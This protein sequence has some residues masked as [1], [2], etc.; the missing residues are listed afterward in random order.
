[1]N[2]VDAESVISEIRKQSNNEDEIIRGIFDY[3]F[4]EHNDRES[5]LQLLRVENTRIK[6]APTS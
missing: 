5:F 6:N 3:A 2:T 4:H 1:M